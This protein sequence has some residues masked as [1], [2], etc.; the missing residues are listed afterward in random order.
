MPSAQELKDQG[1]RVLALLLAD[2]ERI[3]ADK[4]ASPTD[5]ATIARFLKDNNYTVDPKNLPS[6]LKDLLRS[7]GARSLPSLDELPPVVSMAVIEG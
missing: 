3:L 5:R 1:D 6:A 2:F 7:K 4:T